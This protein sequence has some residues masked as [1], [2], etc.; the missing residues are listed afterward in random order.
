MFFNRFAK[1]EAPY[2][3]VVGMTGV[4]LGD[5]LLQIGC[6]N[7]GPL[8]AIAAKVGLSGR[9]LAVVQDEASA[10][11]AQKAAANFGVL[12]D[13]EL[14]SDARLPV[15]DATFDLVVVD[16]SAGMFSAKKPEDRAATLREAARAVRPGGRA[17]IIGAAP[18]HGWSAL[19]SHGPAAPSIATAGDATTALE[20]A[21]F[22]GARILAEREGL[23]FVEGIRPRE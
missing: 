19:L 18:R 2:P 10:T 21:G 5:R 1:R 8:A 3:L 20:S 16:D 15:D 11:R 12:V 9:A 14:S 23:V 22:R 17:M 4:K 7:G 13:V 6:S